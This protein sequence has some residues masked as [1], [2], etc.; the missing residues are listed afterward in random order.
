MSL[1]PQ[2][3][4]FSPT[5]SL[6]LLA[7]ALTSLASAQVEAPAE[8]TGRW[9][10]ATLGDG[11]IYSGYRGGEQVQSGYFSAVVPLISSIR[12][13]TLGYTGGLLFA[14]PYGNW[15]EGG[16]AQA[17]MG[18]GYRYLG[19][20]TGKGLTKNGYF[21]G[22]NAF[23]D[24]ADTPA[25]MRFWQLGL[26]AE[27]GNDWLELR[28]RYMVPLGR[29]YTTVSHA[30]VSSTDTTRLGGKTYRSETLQMATLVTEVESMEG[31]SAEAAVRLPFSQK[32]GD[33][34]LLAGHAGFFSRDNAAADLNSWKVGA[35]Y[36]PLPA[37]VAGVTWFE[38]ER[39]V[40]DH[41][42]AN[43]GV[44]LPLEVLT[45][46]GKGTSFWS[47]LKGA[48]RQ[49]KPILRDRM[50][51]SAR[52][53]ALPIQLAVTP[54]LEAIHAVRLTT[55]D[56]NVPGQ[57]ETFDF[58]GFLVQVQT[59]PS[60]SA[61]NWP[62]ALEFY[63]RYAVHGPDV[64]PLS[65]GAFYLNNLA[66]SAF[67][68]LNEVPF[69]D[70]TL[71]D[72]LRH[73]GPG[74]IQRASGNGGYYQAY[75]KNAALFSINGRPVSPQEFPDASRTESFG[76]FAR[77]VWESE[78]QFFGLSAVIF[79]HSPSLNRSSGIGTG[80]GSSTTSSVTTASS[81]SY[82]S[83]S[84]TTNIT[85]GTFSAGDNLIAGAG[86]MSSGTTSS[87]GLTSAGSIMT[88]G[89]LSTGSFTAN[90]G[91]VFNLVDW[92]SAVLTTTAVTNSLS[93]NFQTSAQSGPGSG[94]P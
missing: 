32:L 66:P 40:G 12:Q 19:Q 17:G 73:P 20:P 92:S 84:S 71:A 42:M 78:T 62:V 77:R 49:T 29:G 46:D 69:S 22:A 43:V 39:L 35:E 86:S 53:N 94:T 30:F 7:L 28:A 70:D 41:W 38:D 33:L 64:E 75:N 36:R 1:F 14:E 59:E 45:G 16:F 11:A 8:K 63:D 91:D 74:L 76:R 10:G 82:V 81:S 80:S 93:P 34:R 58:G 24:M 50:S 56:V 55:A 61:K 89:A 9:H 2:Q 37:L 13:E 6:G 60:F 21:L 44:E 85:S 54:R 4:H 15:F 3:L 51:G 90:S 65:M 57:F 18:F 27:A 23:I 31:W 79:Q 68:L 47:R 83:G 87:G 52:G 25:D 5:A 48:F 26:G 88:L 72:A 67:S